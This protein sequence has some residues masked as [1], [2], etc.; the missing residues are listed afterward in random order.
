MI[1]KAC[2]LEEIKQL[3]LRSCTNEITVTE[4][5]QNTR[6]VEDLGMDSV[7]IIQL[8][9]NIESKYNIIFEDE[10]LL[11]DKLNTVSSLYGYILKL[12]DKNSA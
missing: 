8:I 5:N 12:L 2:L 3:I 7:S 10:Y 11:I 6:L 4:I 1:D 9:C